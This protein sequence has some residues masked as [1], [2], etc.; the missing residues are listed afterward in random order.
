MQSMFKFRR[1]SMLSFTL[2]LAAWLALFPVNRIQA[3]VEL[4]QQPYLPLELALQAASAALAQCEAD[5]YRVSVAVVDQAGVLKILLKGDGAGPHTVNSS[6]KKAYTS[7]SLGR[8]TGEYAQLIAENPAIEGLR[9][10]DPQILFLAGG[11]P[12]LVDEV[13]VGGIGVGGAPGG[14]F[15]ETCAQVGI[16]SILSASEDQTET[17]AE[18]TPE[19]TATPRS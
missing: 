15:D 8:S 12:I 7:A 1:H 19:A 5:G 18:A 9:N 13:V 16:D 14:Q 17:E 2:V 6:W 3:Q 4:P 11:L 10:M